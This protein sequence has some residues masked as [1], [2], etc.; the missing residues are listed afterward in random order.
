MYIYMHGRAIH[1]CI[2]VYVYQCLVYMHTYTGVPAT[3]IILVVHTGG[4]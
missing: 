4:R 3:P 1:I 2:D